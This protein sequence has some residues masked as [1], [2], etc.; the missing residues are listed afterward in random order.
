MKSRGITLWCCTCHNNKFFV[1]KDMIRSMKCGEEIIM[2]IFRCTG[3]QS[4]KLLTITEKDL[5]EGR[6]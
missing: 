3:C 5:K 6:N 2:G 1:A 4:P